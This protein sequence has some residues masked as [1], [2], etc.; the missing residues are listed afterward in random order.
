MFF[1]S[2]PNVAQNKMKELARIPEPLRCKNNF[3]KSDLSPLSSAMKCSKISAL[4]EKNLE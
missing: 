3:F 4:V 2:I 1:Q